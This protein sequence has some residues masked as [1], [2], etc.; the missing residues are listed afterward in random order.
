MY[1]P[2][3]DTAQARERERWVRRVALD[4]L[5]VCPIDCNIRYQFE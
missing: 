1:K 3:K 2:P 5:N 4:I